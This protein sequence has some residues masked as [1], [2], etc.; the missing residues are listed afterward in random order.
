MSFEWKR[1]AQESIL[2]GAL[3]NSKRPQSFVNGVYPSHVSYGNGCFLYDTDGKRYVDF[4]CGMGAHL[5]GYNNLFINGAI[6]RQLRKGTIFSLSSTKEVEAAERLKQVV[7]F[8]SKMRFTKTGTESCLAAVKIARAI[9]QR[10]RVLSDGYH[11]WSDEF[12]G[13]SPPAHGV[14]NKSHME[15]L[16]SLAQID[17][18]IAAVIV[19]PIVTDFSVERIKYLNQLRETCNKFGVCLIFDEII[20][21]FR[22]QS[23]TVSQYYGIYPDIICLGKALGG[24]S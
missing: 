3:T 24:L 12:V 11:G 4:I 10:A 23:H 19:E 7:P 2:H 20:T 9:S 13:M 15:K 22:W 1:R 6:E 17:H 5:F 14:T 16:T 18:T 21:G 8:V